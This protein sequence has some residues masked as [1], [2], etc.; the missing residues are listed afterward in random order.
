[1][2]VSVREDGESKL[3]LLA[4]PLRHKDV[5][6]ESLFGRCRAGISHHIRLLLYE[7]V[8]QPFDGHFHS[9][10]FFPRLLIV[11]IPLIYKTKY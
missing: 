2:A 8:F 4:D 5:S 11:K 7:I 3:D 10:P 9:T 1:M 6:L